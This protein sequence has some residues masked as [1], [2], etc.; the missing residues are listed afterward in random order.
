MNDA[1]TIS[2]GSTGL[3]VPRLGDVEALEQ[4]TRDWRA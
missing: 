1:A 4:I 3:R 2:V